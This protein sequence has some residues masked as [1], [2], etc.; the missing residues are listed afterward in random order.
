MSN[1]NNNNNNSFRL[2][3]KSLFSLKNKNGSK[4]EDQMVFDEGGDRQI[5]QKGTKS[6]LDSSFTNFN[7]KAFLLVISL[8]LFLVFA[9]IFYIQIFSKKHYKAQAKE[10]RQRTIPIKA[11]RGLIFT[12]NDVKLTENVPKFSL[13]ISPKDLPL[14]QEARQKIIEKLADLTNQEIN[15]TKKKLR[16]YDS[17]N[18]ES[19]VIKENLNYESALKLQISTAKLPGVRLLRGSKRLYYLNPNSSSSKK[20]KSLSHILGYLGKISQ[21]E[22]KKFSKKGYLPSDYLGKAGLEQ[23]YESQLRGKYG[24]KVIEVNA[25]GEKKK[26]ISRTDP[27]PGKHLDLYLDLKIQRKL[28]NLLNK[29]LK[30]K[31]KHKA[32]AIAMNPNSGGVLGLVSLPAF[33]NNNFAAGI[34]KTQYKKYLNDPNNPLFNRAVSG[35]YPPGSTIKPFIAA[36]ALEEGVVDKQTT[37]DSTGGIKVGKWFFPDWKG[38]GH[39]ITNITK[40]IAWSVN[41]YFY[42]ISGGYEDFEGMGLST[43][44]QYLVKFGFDKPTGI[45]LPSENDGFLPTK[46]WKR[47][48]KG[49]QWYIGDTYNLSIGQGNLLTTPMQIANGTASIAN[50]GVLYH[51]NLV[52]QIRNPVNNKIIKQEKKILNKSFISNSNITIIQEGMRE[53]VIYG[54]CKKLSLLNLEIA[55]KTGTAQ[56][57]KD[58]KP[59]SWFTSYAPYGDP[60]IVLTILVE[61]GGGGDEVAAD[62]SYDFYQWWNKNYN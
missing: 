44:N 16:Q 27:V 46:D 15:K 14:K 43:I 34:N 50:G 11:K 42:Y 62:I 9:K 29:Y 6:F 4:N 58:K 8:V 54:S 22:F 10:N 32:V 7:K 1:K 51:P 19:I 13:A 39:G 45:D 33:N 49:E 38:S 40:A 24:K 26:V 60:E 35:E 31:N 37:F 55:G 48:Q 17:Y 53:C 20:V 18:V 12:R 61:S 57:N 23:S 47:N 3:N 5:A 25:E 36:A 56:W 59:H 28:E 21:D 41:T 52:K 30:K 2:S